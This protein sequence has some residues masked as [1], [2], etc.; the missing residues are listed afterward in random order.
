MGAG[1][2]SAALPSSHLIGFV[3]P[4]SDQV[5]YESDEILML[6]VRSP[7]KLFW[8]GVQGVEVGA[9]CVSA[10]SPALPLA[11]PSALIAI[12]RP[13][14]RP[15]HPFSAFAPA[16]LSLLLGQPLFIW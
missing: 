12:A 13:S 10:A 15:S 9:A 7:V 2:V 4:A 1:C 16:G 5:L 8:H 14:G 6:L 3:V 11:K